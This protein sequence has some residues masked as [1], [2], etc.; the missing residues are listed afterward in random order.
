MLTI[1]DLWSPLIQIS[2]FFEQIGRFLQDFC[3]IWARTCPTSCA[4]AESGELIPDFVFSAIKVALARE[5]GSDLVWHIFD[6]I[7]IH[8]CTGVTMSCYVHL[9]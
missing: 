7:N 9:K 1:N 3:R 5:P 8:V 6:Q 2:V 4:S